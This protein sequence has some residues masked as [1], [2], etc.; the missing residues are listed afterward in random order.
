VT[1]ASTPFVLTDAERERVERV[2]QLLASGQDCTGALMAQL[3][4][5][6]WTV[7][8]AVVAGLASLGD[9]AVPAL[10]Q[11]LSKDRRN[12]T[13]L[14]ALA[15][16]LVASTGNVT[17]AMAGLANDPNPAVAADAAQVL[18][19]REDGRAIPILIALTEHAHDN[20][21]V[22]AIEALGRVGGRAAI[23]PLVRA[24]GSGNFFRVF[25]AVDVLGRSG[26]PRAV[27][28]LAALLEHRLYAL[29]VA[30]A[31]GRSGN[32]SAVPP[33]AGLLSRA[34]NAEV[35]V[36]ALA[37]ADLM[38]RFRRTYGTAAPV[39]DA[40]RK[41]VQTR[42]AV[43]ALG[44]A[45]AGADP[46]EKAAI[47]LTA[48]MLQDE[49]A[50]S[51]LSTLLRDSD[52]NVVTAAAEGLRNAGSRFEEVLVKQ[53]RGES[54]ARRKLLL[55]LV[56]QS[57]SAPDVARCLDDE[58]PEVR[59]AACDALA[60]IGNTVVTGSLFVRLADSNAAVVQAAVSAIQTL[61]GP[62]TETLAIASSRSPSPSV[63]RWALRI[64]GYFGSPLALEVCLAG[65][66]DE[67]V[68][69]RDSA[70]VGLPFIDDPRARE[71]LYETAKDSVPRARAAAMRALGACR[72]DVRALAVL[73]RGLADSD[74]WVRYYACQSL[75]RLEAESAA[76]AIARLVGDDA[77]Q[78]RVAAVEALAYL[79]SSTAHARLVAAATSD[80]ADVQRA[81][82]IGLG[83]RRAPES[84]PI[85]MMA[86]GSP[87]TATRIVALGALASYD[88]DRVTQELA[89][90]ALDPDEGVRNAAIGFLAG[91]RGAT[92]ALIGLLSRYRSL[93]RLHEALAHPSADRVSG[94]LT[95]LGSADDEIAPLLTSAL[96]RMQR[97][98]TAGALVRALQFPH[99][100]A[101][102]AA[103]MT[104][105]G[106]GTREALSALR[107][108][109]ANDADREVRR[110]CALVLA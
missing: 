37:L 81:S 73:M 29:E 53:L 17:D 72:S 3:D 67:D 80:D 101:R 43:R 15:D 79:K 75:G 22:A 109:S 61:G 110:I 16:A 102:K 12:E 86:L 88:E 31:L 56:T 21:A 2:D 84:L 78:V 60:R 64:L 90:A 98:E 41:A 95:A 77:G 99:L 42:Q 11:R 74:A 62:E 82:L 83:L 103:A 71:A 59:I 47:A 36:G 70:I 89:R 93:P 5:P 91:R 55:P 107:T 9:A 1:A 32:R 63:R 92:P 45:L 44:A 24:A 25:P 94:L 50:V 46:S 6:S 52:E 58:D 33:L 39:E 8:R 28:A 26:D 38:E 51:L 54:S 27:P 23:E 4:D 97:P 106:I 49:A 66:K 30:R 100:P 14:A 104:L 48:G 76:E 13:V 19:R 108:A 34:S 40:L 96:A 18:G 105:A 69:V 20:V 87:D 10:V 85:L 57:E 35:R 68:R 65:M 7:R